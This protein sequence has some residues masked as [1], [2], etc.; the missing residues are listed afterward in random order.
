MK[1]FKLFFFAILPIVAVT[2]FSACNKDDNPDPVVTVIDIT[3]TVTDQDGAA[4]DGVAVASSNGKMLRLP[5]MASTR[6]RVL[7]RQAP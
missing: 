6:S 1:N 5:P 7:K 2:A 3:G 4:L